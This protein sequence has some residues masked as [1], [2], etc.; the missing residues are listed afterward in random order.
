MTG[1]VAVLGGVVARKTSKPELDDSYVHRH[2][3]CAPLE[4]RGAI[5]RASIL[6]RIF[7]DESSARVVLF[8]GPA[9][10]GKSTLLQQAMTISEKDGAVTG[11]MT[12]DDSDNDLQ[13]FFSHFEVLLANVRSTD[14]RK[15]RPLDEG[16]SGKGLRWRIDWLM[17][18]LASTDKNVSL[19]F[20]E[21]QRLS[22][23]SILSFF[24]GFLERLPSTVRIFIA[25]RTLPQIGLARL[26]VNRQGIV[27][28]ADELRFSASE[29]AKF[30][31]LSEDV[32]IRDD[33]VLAIFKQTE[34]WPAALQLFRLTL[35][36]PSIRTALADLQSFRLAELAEYLVDNVLTLQTTEI[37]E[38]LLRTS[39]LERLCAPLCDAVCGR[40][41]SQEILLFLEQSGLFLR[42]LDVEQ[43]WFRFHSLFSSFLE[44]QLRTLSP[45]TILEVHGRACNWY[46]GQSMFGD[47]IRHAAA[48]NDNALAAEILSTWSSTLIA[49]AHFK[50]VEHWYERLPLDE[51]E[52]RP[53]LVVR[54]AWALIFLRRHSK[55]RPI[56]SMLESQ[57][58]Q[59]LL[60]ADHDLHIILA[61]SSLLDDNFEQTASYISS[62]E[63]F[64][65]DSS[66]FQ[67]F[68]LGAAAN[69]K[70]FLTL[71]EGDF[72]RTLSYTAM[73]RTHSERANESFAW[74]YSFSIAGLALIMSGRLNEAR[75]RMRIALAEPKVIVDDSFAAVSLAATYSYALY[76]SNDLDAAETQLLGCKDLI[77]QATLLDWVSV[78]YITMARIHD[79]RGRS[80]QADAVLDDAERIG[81]ANAWP[82]LVKIVAWE[83]VR[84]LILRGALGEARSKASRIGYGEANV[85][86]PPRWIPFSEDLE[87]GVVGQARLLIHLGQSKDAIK[88][89]GSE[90]NI[91]QQTGRLRRLV[92][93]MTLTAIAHWKM[94]NENI[95]CRHFHDALQSACRCGYVRTILDEGDAITSLLRA[96]Y[97][98]TSEG[99]SYS[100]RSP[101]AFRQY[102]S[103]LL[104]LSGAGLS[105]VRTARKATKLET[106]TER[107]REILAFL[108]NGVSNME[109]GKKLF[110]SENTV[111]YHLKNIYS[112]LGVSSRLQAILA[113]RQAG[114][115]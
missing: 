37:Q 83:K 91:A 11:W 68:H 31:A 17:D 7:T 46:R 104:D 78:A 18:G 36:S 5:W 8:Q 99:D 84:R 35:T 96:E 3:L 65:V 9:G 23:P 1:T 56:L 76:E 115:I 79:I 29:A 50:T 61:M 54:V 20:D 19:F 24:R 51:V 28:H 92:K 86:L 93:L 47:A 100:P 64:G 81:L 108:A 111:K 32:T 2:K 71:L 70:A 74:G 82:R 105:R 58:A 107:E 40:S 53:D 72:D 73:S 102:V 106:F 25:S 34:G 114:L 42:S 75:D 103:T 14:T 44:A 26:T 52:G 48:A 85:H 12:F 101:P 49:E 30:F 89:L 67:A 63:V 90:L 113:G 62:V 77:A 22:D 43:Y 80:E 10:H 97:E 21:F 57:F 110:V 69:L 60:R 38:F 109:M 88:L 39:L 13:R 59:G 41:G 98:A 55:L 45:D 27:F 33:E 4:Y 6:D 15:Q 87:G 95:A 94:G 112:K 16:E 66:G